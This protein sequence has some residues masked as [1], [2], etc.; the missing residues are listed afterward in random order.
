MVAE[1]VRELCESDVSG[2]VMKMEF[3]LREFATHVCGSGIAGCV[4]PI[5][6]IRVTGMVRWSEEA[7]AEARSHARRLALRDAMGD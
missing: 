1:V 7:L 3:C 4:A 6:K 2:Q 5:S